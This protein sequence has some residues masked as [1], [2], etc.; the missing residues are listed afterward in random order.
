M[1]TPNR[2]LFSFLNT[3]IP[4]NWDRPAF[5]DYGQP[6]AYTFGQAARQMA[7]L[8]K[9]YTQLGIEAGDRIAIYGPNSAN[10]AV[11]FFSI[12]AHGAVVV[13][14]LP[15]FTPA[16]AA[17]LV[18]HSE[19]KLLLASAP[20]AAKLDYA[21]MPGLTAVVSLNDWS[22]PFVAEKASQQ[23][24]D[25]VQLADFKPSDV[26]YRDDNFD[27]LALINYTSGTTSSPKGVMLTY[28]SLST[29]LTFIIEHFYTTPDM[30]YVS[31]LPLAHMFGMSFEL[32]YHFAAG[33]PLFFLTKLAAPV[34]LQAYHDCKPYLIFSV[35][36]VLE[37]IYQKNL[38]PVVTKPMIRFCWNIPGIGTYI[39]RR[40]LKGLMEAFGGN[41]KKVIIGGAALSEEVERCLMDVGFPLIVGYGLTECGPLIGYRDWTEFVPRSCGQTV[42]RMELRIDSADP[43]NIPGEVQVRGEAVM[44]GYYRN[45]EA[46]QASFTDD[47]WLRTGDMGVV[48]AEGNIFL[49]GRCKTMLLSS[50]G[51]NIYPEE[52]EALLN[53]QPG[54]METLVVQRDN[55]LVAL[56]VPESKKVRPARI[57]RAV[58]EVNNHLPAYSK[59][60]TYEIR[61]D[62][63]E[64]T[65]KKSI[66]R[67]LY[68]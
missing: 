65:P 38:R 25:N 26:H 9:L 14:I 43:A 66:K 67:F 51:Q 33:V 5:T 61:T 52:I 48:D 45:E 41:V 37:K 54:I 20:L 3:T 24:I 12:L 23:S 64:K 1:N 68:S 60:L 27:D 21:A 49:R 46:T 6:T 58:H 17:K 29:N 11:G 50:S 18:N 55:K 57:E 47:G 16:D 36:M 40:V 10:W 63:F 7:S 28:R 39:R 53:M 42:D 4:A 2:H 15:D 13:S 35:P 34:V 31:I 8:S 62:E 22:L 44:S 32:I 30:K 59:I 56:I 19:A